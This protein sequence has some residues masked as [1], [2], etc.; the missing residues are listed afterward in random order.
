MDASSPPTAADGEP[1]ATTVR[2]IDLDAGV[3]ATETKDGVLTIAADRGT[4]VHYIA[5]ILLHYAKHPLV[6]DA[7]ITAVFRARQV[8][9]PIYAFGDRSDWPWWRP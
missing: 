4:P 1:E 8:D 7:G 2:I 3:T 5:S 6:L 9:D